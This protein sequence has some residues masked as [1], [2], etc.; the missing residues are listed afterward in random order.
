VDWDNQVIGYLWKWICLGISLTVV[1]HSVVSLVG[2]ES[3]LV[4]LTRKY[5]AKDDCHRCWVCV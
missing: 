2:L 5:A 4:G 3:T 1:F